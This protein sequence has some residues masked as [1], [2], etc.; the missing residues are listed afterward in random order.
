VG[1]LNGQEIIDE[2]D[3]Y[4]DND[5][6]QRVNAA[7]MMNSLPPRLRRMLRTRQF[8]PRVGRLASLKNLQVR[9]A[10]WKLPAVGASVG[11]V[12]MP[13]RGLEWGI[14]SEEKPQP[15]SS[16]PCA[17]RLSERA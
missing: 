2:T 13:Q 17:P 4:V 6:R 12:G 9:P 7:V 14:A 10:V 11:E 15:L 5:R 3:R 8:K 16:G 1:E